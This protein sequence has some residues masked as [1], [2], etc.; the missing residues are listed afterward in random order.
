MIQ[1]GKDA[2]PIGLINHA[3][4]PGQ[5]ALYAEQQQQALRTGTF[6]TYPKAIS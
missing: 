5:N 2:D 6:A 4:K 1:K 3:G